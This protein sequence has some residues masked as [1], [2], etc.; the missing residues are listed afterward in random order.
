MNFA[1]QQI[2]SIDRGIDGN[3][4]YLLIKSDEE[5]S[6]EDIRRYLL[7]TWAWD[8]RGAGQYFCSGVD[9]T[10]HAQAGKYIG[11]IYHR[12]DV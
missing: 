3:D 7:D 12:Y 6:P 1:V 4:E 5:T 2:G 8:C 11:I 10:P 9:V